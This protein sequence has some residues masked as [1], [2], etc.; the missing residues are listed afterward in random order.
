L[1]E[2]WSNLVTL[3]SAF[4]SKRNSFA[5]LFLLA[6][7]MKIHRPVKSPTESISTKNSSTRKIADQKFANPNIRRPY[8]TAKFRRPI[9]KL[10]I[11]VELLL[12]IRD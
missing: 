5:V 3:F 8:N 6:L 1:D 4:V 2:N 9:F 11:F 12:N 10:R 7:S